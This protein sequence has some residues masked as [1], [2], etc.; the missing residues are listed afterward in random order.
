M[1][2]SLWAKCWK[3]IVLHL[4]S[5]VVCLTSILC[6]VL[7]FLLL[8][9]LVCLLSFVPHPSSFIFHSLSCFLHLWCFVFCPLAAI[10]HSLSFHV[11][12]H[13]PSISVFLSGSGGENS[14]SSSTCTSSGT[15]T[16]GV[17]GLTF[18]LTRAYTEFLSWSLNSTAAAERVLLRSSPGS[19]LAGGDDTLA[20]RPPPMTW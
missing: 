5:F 19:W 1:I 18:L 8:S 12:H 9:L 11:L 20:S 17:V 14:S 16:G 7:S 3:N 13:H 6:H 2:C 4:S 15:W 10:L